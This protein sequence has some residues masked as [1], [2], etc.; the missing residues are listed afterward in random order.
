M[1]GYFWT[2]INLSYPMVVINVVVKE[3]LETH[4]E[5]GVI[6]SPYRVVFAIVSPMFSHTNF[7]LNL[8]IFTGNVPLRV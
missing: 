6:C 5:S 1:G 7:I 3:D 2:L 8:W 4:R